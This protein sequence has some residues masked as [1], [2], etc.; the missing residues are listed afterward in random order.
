[1][2]VETLLVQMEIKRDYKKR[3]K[4]NSNHNLKRQYH[5]TTD[6]FQ[7]QKLSVTVIS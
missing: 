2:L 1:M 7:N 3:L 6:L 5:V 4:F